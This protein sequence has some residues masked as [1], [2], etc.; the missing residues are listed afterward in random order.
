L[1]D[2]WNKGIPIEVLPIAYKIAK[3]EIEKQLGGEVVVRE[4]TEKVVCFRLNYNIFCVSQ[5]D[6]LDFLGSCAN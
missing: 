6:T 5:D 3:K 4:G 1:G 2:K